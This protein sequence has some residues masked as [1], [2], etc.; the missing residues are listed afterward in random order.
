MAGLEKAHLRRPAQSPSPSVP[1]SARNWVLCKGPQDT[2]QIRAGSCPFS[3]LT[4]QT[5][6]FPSSPCPTLLGCGQAS[7]LQPSPLFSLG[8]LLRAIGR[9]SARGGAPGCVWLPPSKRVLWEQQQGLTS[10]WGS[11]L[12]GRSQATRSFH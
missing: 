2:G 9:T 4:I 12:G 11:E 7:P 8:L 1:V 10:C 3:G 6:S 5:S